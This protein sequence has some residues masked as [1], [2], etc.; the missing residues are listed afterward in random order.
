MML[1]P[2]LPAVL[3]LAVPL[4][5]A[6]PF[7][8]STVCAFAGYPARNTPSASGIKK[9]LANAH[10]W[11]LTTDLAGDL[12]GIIIV[13]KCGDPLKTWRN[14]FEKSD[15][16]LQNSNA[17]RLH[18]I[19][20][21]IGAKAHMHFPGHR[22]NRTNKPPLLLPA[23]PEKRLPCMRPLGGL[24]TLANPC[25]P[26][27][28]FSYPASLPGTSPRLPRASKARQ[29]SD[30]PGFGIIDQAGWFTWWP[31]E[32]AQFLPRTNRDYSP[33]EQMLSMCNSP[34]G[35]SGSRTGS[36]SSVCLPGEQV[37]W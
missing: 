35:L 32:R 23:K 19:A 12:E 17:Y 1:F 20:R 9:W 31:A 8:V 14:L 15:I 24:T 25:Q 2:Q 3:Q 6:L 5:P 36:I 13:N 18:T 10:G 21:P 22:C 4:A 29:L 27:P 37:E 11:N 16:F 30:R 34:S 33:A 28:T 7:Q 26:L